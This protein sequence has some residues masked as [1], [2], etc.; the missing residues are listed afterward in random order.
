[1]NKNEMIKKN[2][3]IDNFEKQKNLV[4]KNFTGNDIEFEMTTIKLYVYEAL[5]KYERNNGI[6][7][8][9][10]NKCLIEFLVEKCR[11]GDINIQHYID[12][13]MTNVNYII[14][15]LTTHTENLKIDDIFEYYNTGLHKEEYCSEIYKSFFQIVTLL[16]YHVIEDILIY[17]EYLLAHKY[18]SEQVYENIC[19]I[20]YE[21]IKNF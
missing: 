2:F 12:N 16:N 1:M 6:D 17:H 20:L 13:I 15:E 11:D 10:K 7:Y 3:N 8:A 18:M 21:M 9:T 5:Y 14:K 4:Y 19:L